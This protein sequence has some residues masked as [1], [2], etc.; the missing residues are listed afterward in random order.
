MEFRKSAIHNVEEKIIR[1][2]ESLGER[3]YKRLA[4]MDDDAQR[5]FEEM[6][7]TFQSTFWSQKWWLIVLSAVLS[8][9]AVVVMNR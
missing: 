3:F 7:K 4:T 6:G 5:R 8:I 2:N 9:F 1:N